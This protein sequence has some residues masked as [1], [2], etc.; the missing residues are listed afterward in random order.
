MALWVYVYMGTTPVGSIITGTIISAAGARAALL[1]GAAA[2][3]VA[4]GIASRVHTPPHVDQALIDL[5]GS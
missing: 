1:T 3:L 4:A 2:C 5:A